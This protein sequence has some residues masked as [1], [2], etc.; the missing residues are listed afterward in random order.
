MG[1]KAEIPL[2]AGKL[3]P[4]D[5]LLMWPRGAKKL[6]RPTIHPSMEVC[7][8]GAHHTCTGAMMRE[9]PRFFNVSIKNKHRG[10]SPGCWKH[11]I[12]RQKPPFSER[13]FN[14]CLV[15]DPAFWIQSLAR[16]PSEGTFYE[17]F[18]L[19][20]QVVYGQTQGYVSQYVTVEGSNTSQLF[21][22]VLFDDVFYADALEVWLATVRSYFD[23]SLFPEARTA[24][25]RCEDFQ[26]HFEEVMREL[27]RR[28][29]PLRDNL[30]EKFEALDETAKDPSHPD[31]TRRNRQELLAYYRNP[32][33]RLRRLTVNQRARLEHLDREIVVPLGYGAGENVKSWVYP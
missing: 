3:H 28:G 27:A 4:L 19:A 26:F 14:I 6:A 8:F 10:D 12:I 21:G 33:N 2:Y 29:L 5:R 20:Q 16:S 17:I 11:S 30:P 13:Q 25:V 1:A 18:P 9:L 7:V 31:C 23:I 32:D 22:P 15:K 24:V